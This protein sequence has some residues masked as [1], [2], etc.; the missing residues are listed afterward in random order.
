M[1]TSKKTNC[2]F[3]SLGSATGAS[4]RNFLVKKYPCVKIHN[5]FSLFIILLL[6]L[7]PF[8]NVSAAI[9]KQVNYQGKLTNSAGVAVADG[10]YN[11]EFV[12]YDDPTLGGAH[13]LWTETRTTT[14][15]V[16]V[17]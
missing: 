15:K 4:T 6:L 13:I 7:S 9:N 17:N 1:K 10:T 14:D 11:M 5:L 8:A 12:L 16:Q 3:Y 2:E